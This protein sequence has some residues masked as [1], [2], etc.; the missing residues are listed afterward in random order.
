MS[1]SSLKLILKHLGALLFEI[2]CLYDKWNPLEL[3]SLV[4]VQSLLRNKLVKERATALNL[5]LALPST[6]KNTI[7]RE[8]KMERQLDSI[9]MKQAE[10]KRLLLV[11]SRKIKKKTKEA[12]EDVL[13]VE[14]AR[15]YVKSKRDLMASAVKESGVGSTILIETE[16]FVALIS[17]IKECP[18]CGREI[19]LRDAE[20]MKCVVKR[21]LDV[22]IRG[23]CIG[24]KGGTRF[25]NY[26]GSDKSLMATMSPYSAIFSGSTHSEEAR[27]LMSF[28]VSLFTPESTFYE[29]QDDETL[30]KLQNYAKRSCLKALRACVEF[31]PSNLI[32][33]TSDFSWSHRRDAAQGTCTVLSGLKIRL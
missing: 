11:Q 26:V 27:V 21:G 8:R 28:G 2:L 20:D 15:D 13:A 25:Q 17:Q 5:D 31:E 32:K 29:S 1:K 6:I 16:A 30:M 12:Q 19:L 14:K 33:V 23:R 10:S 18:E 3:F 7:S 24:C 22:T 4:T 9:R